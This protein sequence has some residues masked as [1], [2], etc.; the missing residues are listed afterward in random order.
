MKLYITTYALSKGIQEIDNY[1]EVGGGCI[2]YHDEN[3]RERLCPYP[4]WFKT[5]KEAIGAAEGMRTA[6]LK[7]LKASVDK[8]EKLQFK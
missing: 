1:D 6:K 3:N 4:E 8:L 7:L 5:K 2:R